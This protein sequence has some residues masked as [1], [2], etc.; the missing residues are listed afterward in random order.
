MRPNGIL[1]AGLGNARF[2][3][4]GLL[5]LAWSVL[6]CRIPCRMLLWRRAGTG[7]VLVF[8]SLR[9]TRHAGQVV[10]AG[11]PGQPVGKGVLLVTHQVIV[12]LPP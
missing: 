12:S 7:A 1:P 5:A 3:L 6:R 10:V 2:K 4:Y 9:V 11:D 8:D